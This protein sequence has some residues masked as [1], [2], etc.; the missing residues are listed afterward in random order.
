MSTKKKP[1]HFCV[2]VLMAWVF[3]TCYMYIC[4]VKRNLLCAILTFCKNS[5]LHVLE[6]Q[7]DWLHLTRE[8]FYAVF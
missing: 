2:T 1:V 4:V 5:F 6:S 8:I 3:L 7:P